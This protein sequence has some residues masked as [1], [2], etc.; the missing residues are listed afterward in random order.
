MPADARLLHGAAL[1]VSEAALTGESAPVD[2]AI[3]SLTTATPLA[4][5]HNMVHAGTHVTAGRA[6]AV[7]TATG[8][9]TELGRIAGLAEAATQPPTP[10][11]RR[12]AQVGRHVIVAAAVLFSASPSQATAAA[13]S[14]G[15]SW[16]RST[17]RR[18][19]LGSG[20]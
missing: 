10:L 18:S 16:T 19:T 13:P 6:R 5:R 2:K 3:S 11:E 4:D 1:Q 15:A 7:V 9:A 20:A 8:L 12:I 17:S 14:T